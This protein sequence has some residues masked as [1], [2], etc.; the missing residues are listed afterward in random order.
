LFWLDE[1]Q[2]CVSHAFADSDEAGDGMPTATVDERLARRK[3]EQ[4]KAAL[5]QH[6]PILSKISPSPPKKECREKNA[7]LYVLEEWNDAEALL[8]TSPEAYAHTVKTQTDTEC[9]VVL[10]VR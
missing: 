6:V 8:K 5:T 1:R 2:L 9:K 4:L 10:I 3:R 7:V